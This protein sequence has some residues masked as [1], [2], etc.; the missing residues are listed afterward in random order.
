MKLPF[1]EFHLINFVLLQMVH[2]FASETN[3]F[4]PIKA[5]FEL[6]TSVT[7]TIFQQGRHAGNTQLQRVK[8]I[9]W[10]WCLYSHYFQLF[11]CIC[12]LNPHTQKQSSE[13]S[14]FLK[15][16]LFYEMVWWLLIL[17]FCLRFLPNEFHTRSIQGRF[18]TR[19]SDL[20]PNA[21]SPVY[22]WY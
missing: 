12:F 9:M 1:V 10:F 6:V 17:L 8:E 3:H 21:F 18:H 7:L 14:M 22:T 11:A 4:P 19:V 20:D 2:I 15:R 16:F 13:M 5:L